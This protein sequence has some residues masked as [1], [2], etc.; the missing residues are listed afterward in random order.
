M[1]FTKGFEGPYTKIPEK[2]ELTGAE[3]EDSL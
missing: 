2:D 3:K 1:V